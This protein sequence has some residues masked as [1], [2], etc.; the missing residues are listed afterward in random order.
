MISRGI[1]GNLWMHMYCYILREKAPDLLKEEGR[2]LIAFA[3]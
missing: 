1:L 2:A 3:S